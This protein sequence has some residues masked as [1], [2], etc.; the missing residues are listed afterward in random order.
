MT[1]L[2]RPGWK[3]GRL[4]KGLSS[5]T[6]TEGVVSAIARAAIVRLIDSPRRVPATPVEQ[7]LQVM[8]KGGP[9]SLE[10][11]VKDVAAELYEEELR[12]GAG[13]LDIGLFGSGLFNG[14]VS[15]ELKAGD[16]ILWKIGE[17][18]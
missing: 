12:M 7:R 9:V 18:K 4:F 10:Q 17:L 13:V 3:M 1:G 14:D 16:G 15:R 5:Q 11:L 2:Q 6:D 8:L